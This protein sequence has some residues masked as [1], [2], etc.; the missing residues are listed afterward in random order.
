MTNKV[1][2]WK[3]L[4]KTCGVFHPSPEYFNSESRDRIEL[5]KKG[6]DFNSEEEILQWMASNKVPNGLK[7]RIIDKKNIPQ[8]REF[9]NAW[10]DEFETETV[11][12]HNERAKEIQLQHLRNVRKKAYEKLNTD[13]IIAL[14][15]EDED[16]LKSIREKWRKLKDS[17]EPLKSFEVKEHNCS[18][19]LAK[20]K[21]LGVLS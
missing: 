2:I 16:D 21:E 3:N 9:R 4:D 8:N 7:F 15:G 12:V 14:L 17:T 20:I 19:T 11:D 6:I 1:I 13:F 10:T 18:K 5:K